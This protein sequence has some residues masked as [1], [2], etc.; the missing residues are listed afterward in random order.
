[1]RKRFYLKHRRKKDGMVGI[2]KTDE[3]AGAVIC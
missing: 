3:G 1:M 2:T